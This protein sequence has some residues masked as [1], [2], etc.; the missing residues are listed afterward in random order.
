MSA[1]K[2]LTLVV[3]CC[4]IFGGVIAQDTDDIPVLIEARDQP[5]SFWTE[6][7]R[8][9]RPLNICSEEP[10]Y[11]A[12][13]I[14]PT[15][16]W[17]V[18]QTR[19]M[20]EGENSG[21]VPVSTANLW[22]CNPIRRIALQIAGQT[23]IGAEEE[24]FVANSLPSWS[25]DGTKLAW[26]ELTPDSHRLIVY[27]LETEAAE[28]L[29]GELPDARLLPNRVTW[30]QTGI[31]A[32]DST[33]ESAILYS[34]DNGEALA[35]FTARDGTLFLWAADEQG[36][37]QL[38]R[39]EFGDSIYLIDPLTG[40]ETPSDEVLELYSL[41]AG[42]NSLGLQG[43]LVDDFYHEWWIVTPY[44]EAV[45]SGFATT[46]GA[47]YANSVALS[48]AGDAMVFGNGS[49]FLWQDGETTMIPGTED[50]MTEGTSVRWGPTAYRLRESAVPTSIG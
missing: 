50:L 20:P 24:S 4:G 30:G 35:Q 22:L 29:V 19:F 1:F 40:D 21:S 31:L 5:L 23:A 39:Y 45:N 2:Y 32:A 44:G 27:D 12:P 3:L 16:E 37:E 18:L 34:A 49:A 43:V 10:L 38:V 47:I 42:D 7:D 25:P 13:V 41:L 14:S 36:E 17:V 48:P 15:G 9:I 46:Y 11:T 8:N 26:A 6:S 28:V 33:G